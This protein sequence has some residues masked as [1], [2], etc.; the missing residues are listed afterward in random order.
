MTTTDSPPTSTTTSHISTILC[1]DATNTESKT[2]SARLGHSII[3]S[4]Q[5]PS[6]ERWIKIIRWI[7]AED[8]K[9]PR[10]CFVA[11]TAVEGEEMRAKRIKK[12]I[13]DFR[14]L[15]ITHQTGGVTRWYL[16][17]NKAIIVK[18]LQLHLY[19]SSN[20]MQKTSIYTFTSQQEWSYF[21]K[22]KKQPVWS[23]E[24]IRPSSFIIIQ[25]KKRNSCL[26]SCPHKP[27]RTPHV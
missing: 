19:K 13:T 22:K 3:P 14:K 21:S 11:Q 6:S 8:K 25:E 12:L 20:L 9:R 26:C 27:Y 5:P 16:K 15:I 18:P 1:H 17:K 10:T 2:T 23:P 4:W 7:W 24:S